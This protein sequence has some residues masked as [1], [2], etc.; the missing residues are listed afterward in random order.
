M[1]TCMVLVYHTPQCSAS[2]KPSF[3]A[4][5]RVDN[6]VIGRGNAEWKT[7]KSGHPSHA[8]SADKVLLQKRLKE[9]LCWIVRHVP[10]D[11]IGQGTELNHLCWIVCHIPPM[12]Q[13]VKELNWTTLV[14]CSLLFSLL[15]TVWYLLTLQWVHACVYCVA[16][17]SCYSIH[18]G[19]EEDFIN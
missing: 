14:L 9:D 5:W 3:G 10:S 18:F 1:E 15:L 12:T 4:P 6:V 19:G 11:P 7:T 8:R 13:S 17:Y 2:P 16:S